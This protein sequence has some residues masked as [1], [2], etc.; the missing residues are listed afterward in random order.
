MSYIE[1]LNIGN[2]AKKHEQLPKLV[3]EY[4]NLYLSV[5]TEMCCPKGK[6]ECQYFILLS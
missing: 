3:M 6:C 1:I 5:D 4:I 2:C